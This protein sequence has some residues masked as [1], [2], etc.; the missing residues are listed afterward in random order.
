[1]T[2]Q[3]LIAR[4]T[5]RPVQRPLSPE[6]AELR[7]ISDAGDKARHDGQND[8]ALEYY[9]RGLARARELRSMP[10]E[11]IFLG[12]IGALQTEQG[13]FEEA[14]N[15]L[16]AGITTAEAMG[17]LA[18]RARAMGNLGAHYLRRGLVQKSQT[19]L[20]Q[21]LEIAKQSGDDAV[22]GLTLANLGGVYLKQNNP[23]YAI[24]ILKEGAEKLQGTPLA[25]QSGAVAFAVGQFGVAHLMLN[26]AERGFR[27][28]TQAIRLAQQAG[29]SSQ[30]LRWTNA[31]AGGLFNAGQL[32]ESLRLY[33]RCEDLLPR[34]HFPDETYRQTALLNRATIH[35][36]LG[37]SDLALSFAQRALTQ[38]QSD[39]DRPLEAKAQALLSEL[40]G[41]IGQIDQAIKSA[42]SATALYE[43]DGVDDKDAQVDALLTLGGLYNTAHAMDS[44]LNTFNKAL[45]IIGG[46]STVARAKVLRRIG[47]TWQERGELQKAVDYWNEAL[48]I[49]D[50]TKQAS[51]AA[52]TV[53]DIGAAK[54]A[55]SGI[56]AALPEYERATMYLNNVK[57]GA[58]RGLVLSNVANLYTDLGEVETAASFFQEAIQLARQSGDRRSESVRLGNYGWFYL[59]TGRPQDT[60][61]LLEEAL[62]ISRPLDDKTL[63]AVQTNNLAQAYHAQKDYAAAR[64]LFG[65]SLALVEALGDRRWKA[66]FQT[67]L[68]R[69]ALAENKIEEALALL[70]QALPVSRELNDQENVIRALGRLGE[71]HLRSD[72]PDQAD[73]AARESESLAR[74]WGYRKGQADA[75]IVRAAVARSRS[76]SAEADR[77]TAEAVRLYAILRDPGAT[78]YA[79]VPKAA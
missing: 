55:M 79:V 35:H 42:E 34:V 78:E 32:A 76:E 6:E 74:K 53:C 17:D 43:G 47:I 57:D 5:G 75:L 48:K 14:E 26:E 1:M 62:A 28:L 2:V 16:Q 63:I 30:E 19:L 54:R 13:R 67:N 58:T 77:L 23:S 73:A 56:N 68:A 39:A 72:M 64:G 71:A 70:E 10:G 3:N 36:R 59:A 22:I 49:F 61:R 65:Q 66:I 11:E 8:L 33:E 4:L 9:E 41:A 18:R 27:M 38:A 29:D 20:E 44:S 15:S 60:I 51:M 52:R 69:T 50:Q 45:E 25:Y 46:D 40:Y 37:Q 12:L 7:R 21:A 24:R 31:L